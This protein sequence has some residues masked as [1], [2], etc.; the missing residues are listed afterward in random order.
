MARSYLFHSLA[1]I[2]ANFNVFS[3]DS[4]RHSLFGKENV[5]AFHQEIVNHNRASL[6]SQKV[7][8]FFFFAFALP[9]VWVDWMVSVECGPKMKDLQT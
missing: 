9:L 3:Q 8:F 6:A 4:R 2:A 5:L 7:I 1:A